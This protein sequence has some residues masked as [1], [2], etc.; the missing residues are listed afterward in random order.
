MLRKR[1]HALRLAVGGV[2]AIVLFAVWGA[3]IAGDLSAHQVISPSMAD[4]LLVG[5]RVIVRRI[6]EQT[7]LRVGDVVVVEAPD[8]IGL[9]LVKRVAA[10]P[11]DTV[12]ALGPFVMINRRV[13]RLDLQHDGTRRR[14]GTQSWTL[15]AGEYFVLGD[16][17]A[18]S[19]DSTS[20]GPVPRASITGRVLFRYA[21]LA[22]AG[23]LEAQGRDF[24]AGSRYFPPS[25]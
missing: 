25:D 21:P 5:D 22:R 24:P 9:P 17:R 15:R 1:P 6:A 12:A 4:T 8:G 11:G 10:G 18:E 2:L 20:F 13:A 3:L 14:H 23:A 19:F 16:N 7:P